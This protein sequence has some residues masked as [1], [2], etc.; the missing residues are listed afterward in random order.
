ME[1]REL[2]ENADELL[3]VAAPLADDAR[4]RDVEERR[5]ALG[6]HRLRQ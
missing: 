6:R 5:A 1:A 3:G 2:E 4:R